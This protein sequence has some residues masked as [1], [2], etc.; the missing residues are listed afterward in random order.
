[1]KGILI[2]VC[3]YFLYWD[4]LKKKMYHNRRQ[5]TL[6]VF[7]YVTISTLKTEF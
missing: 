2:F 7:I 3:V 1:M 4:I 6:N 5:Y